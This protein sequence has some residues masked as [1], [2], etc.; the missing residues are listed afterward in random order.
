MFSDQP[1]SYLK[2]GVV[3]LSLL[4]LVLLSALILPRS[5]Q[6][7][8]LISPG[9]FQGFN[10]SS[11]FSF[12]FKSEGLSAVVQ[13]S[14]EGKDGDYAVYIEDVSDGESYSLRSSDSF[15]AASL[16]KVFLMAAVLKEV[17]EG[18]LGMD[19]T[20][21]ASLDH[22]IDVYG[23]LDFGYDPSTGSGQ[24]EQIEYTVEE[25]LI[26]VGRI[27]DNFAAIMLMDKVGP[28]KVQNITD[29]VG[30]K[31]T[32]S[33]SPIST[34]A[35]D[36]G[37]FFKALYKGEV[38]N[39]NV[40]AKLIEFLSL[41]QLNNRIPAGLPDGVKVVHKTGELPGV[42]HDAG[43]VWLPEPTPEESPPTA[44]PPSGVS[45]EPAG[46][47][48]GVGERAYVIVLMSKDL[49]YEDEGIETLAQISKE[50]YEYFTKKMY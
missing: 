16:Y 36:M 44:G 17:D 46:N 24:G 38:G 22:L 3:V 14:I 37:N 32:S 42:R 10:L 18:D 39:E 21:S 7:K 50:V 2:L 20:L 35:L 23:G 47:T 45:A 25:A 33:K 4:F 12:A 48:P 9:F 40:S 43:I 6:Y 13:K 1:K 15:P 30:A 26:R 31:S 41:N 34:T 5:K 29:S 8:P 11:T 49:K 28:D 27:S 19:D